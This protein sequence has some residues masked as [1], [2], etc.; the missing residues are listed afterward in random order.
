[1]KKITFLLILF[2]FFYGNAQW[3]ADTSVNTLVSNDVTVDSKSVGTTDGKTFVVYWKTTTAPVNYEL[4]LQILDIDG[5]LTLGSNGML[6][7]N[8]IPMSTSTAFWKIRTDTSN[9]LY[10]CVTGTGS[11]TPAIVFKI[12]STGTNLWGSNGVTLGSGYLPTVC[13]LSNGDVLMGYSPGAGQS[14]IQRYT[15]TGT[16][17]WAT[18]I[19]VSGPLAS[20]TTFIADIYELSNQDFIAV[21]H[22]KLSFGVST[23]LFAQRYNSS[24]VVQW[25][26][27]TQ[28]S[29]RTTVY[30]RIYSSSQDN[31]VIY[32]GYYGNDLNRFDSYL[33]RLNADGTLPWG[34]NGADFDTNQ[35]NFE[36]DTQI[37]TIS[38]SNFLWAVCHYTDTNQTIN[39][40]YVQKVDKTTGARLFTN[41][42]KEIFPISSS[43]IVHTADL[44]LIGDTPFFLT[45]NGL[46]TGVSP[47]TLNKVRL[48]TN[49]DF[50]WAAQFLPV[51][52]FAANKSQ[53]HLTEPLNDESVAVFIEPK[54]SGQSLIYAQKFSTILSNNEFSLDSFELY[55]NPSKDN[56]NIEGNTAI[57]SLIVYSTTGQKIYEDSFEGVNKT[58]VSTANWANGIYI[59]EI[60]TDSGD[61]KSY[62]LIKQ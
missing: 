57:K 4:R 32:Y 9:N 56:F 15:S 26:A 10:V 2:N 27:P 54:T 41:T 44:K 37:K 8:T 39:G 59:L 40:E 5:N 55:P 45:K 21:F 16:P 17:V 11:G 48:D 6:I 61:V 1:M 24:G 23:N 62:K 22:K 49:G 53:I 58:N 38:G 42:A 12:D 50:I 20:N 43:H 36:M 29:N 52:T 13:P 14:K 25:A 47:V 3:V 31:D 19:G 33:Q 18:A 34:I 60:K 46:D 51:A 30:N 35:T 28:L 7:S